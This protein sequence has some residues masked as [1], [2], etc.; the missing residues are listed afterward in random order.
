MPRV[1][2]ACKLLY[3]PQQLFDGRRGAGIVHFGLANAV[4]AHL[5]TSA[6]AGFGL[7]QLCAANKRGLNRF[8][9]RVSKRRVDAFR[10]ARVCSASGNL[11]MKKISREGAI[12][13]K[14]EVAV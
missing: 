4:W 1:V 13:N 14:T 2:L 3:D 5:R 6:G 8:D 10:H 9:S 7:Y 11:H 12:P